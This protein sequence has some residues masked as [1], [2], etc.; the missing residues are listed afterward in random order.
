MNKE[1]TLQRI[2][3]TI[4]FIESQRGVVRDDLA[5]RAVSDLQRLA[6]TIVAKARMEAKEQRTKKAGERRA[7]RRARAKAKGR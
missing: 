1:D 4:A 2:K 5:G 6:T 3:A 7:R